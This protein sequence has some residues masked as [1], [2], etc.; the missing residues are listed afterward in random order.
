MAFSS[1]KKS[2]TDAGNVMIEVWSF[3]A[4][5]VT[6]GTISAG[7]SKIHAVHLNNEVSGSVSGQKATYD[8]NGLIT[9]AGVTSNDTGTITVIGNG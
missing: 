5:G 1:A 3:N 7:I 8:A 4:A 9:I 6:T 2:R